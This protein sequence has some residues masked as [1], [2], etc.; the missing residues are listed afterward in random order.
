MMLCNQNII[1]V[2]NR[3]FK[4]WTTD[5][6]KYK[7]LKHIFLESYFTVCNK[8]SADSFSNCLSPILYFS[9]IVVTSRIHRKTLKIPSKKHP[10]KRISP[11]K[12]SKVILFIYLLEINLNS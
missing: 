11:G 9:L 2:C 4:Y 10:G 12:N 6:N 3:F 8:P 1:I 5:T 7:Y